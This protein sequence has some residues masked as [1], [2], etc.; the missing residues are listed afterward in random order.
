MLEDIGLHWRETIIWVET[1]G[2]YSE[3]RFGKDHRNLLRFTRDARRQVFHPRRVLSARLAVYNDR[4][5]NPAG[6]VPSNVWT[7]I[8]RVCGKFREPLADFPSQLPVELLR[9]IV[10]TAS[11]PGDLVVAPFSGSATT[12]VAAVE[13]SRRYLGIER[14][15]AF[16][17]WSRARL[18]GVR[19]VPA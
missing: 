10:E 19:P 14:N 16:A 11:D 1:F 5:A 17:E 12:G 6:R 13:L 2:V 18:A 15:A 4:R 7:D 8:P 9:R 3:T